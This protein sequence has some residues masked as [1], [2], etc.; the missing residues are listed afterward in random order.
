M[1]RTVNPGGFFKSVAQRIGFL[2][3]VE[4]RQPF[5]QFPMAAAWDELAAEMNGDGSGHVVSGKY[6][7]DKFKELMCAHAVK[8][9]N[10][11]NDTGV[12]DQAGFER[13]SA[14]EKEELNVLTGCHAL[15]VTHT[16]RKESK[17]TANKENKDS[18]AAGASMRMMAATS[19]KR[20]KT[21]APA[22]PEGSF[23]LTGEDPG[24][25]LEQQAT[26]RLIADTIE[27]HRLI[28]FDES[29]FVYAR[30]YFS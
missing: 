27:G 25:R 12:D 23:D 29:A 7:S 26:Y 2:E 15:W 9:R 22:G 5:C 30:F 16:K 10:E 1:G 17:S 8:Q 19:F 11:S 18:R 20:S 28:F 21:Q 13:L 4:A 14:E 6:C 24:A 3:E